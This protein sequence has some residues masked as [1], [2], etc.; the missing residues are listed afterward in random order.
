MRLTGFA[1]IGTLF[2][3]TGCSQVT[4]AP[5]VRETV[6]YDILWEKSGTYSRLGRAIRI[7][8]R[9]EATLAQIPVPEVPVDFSSQMVLVAGLGPITSD[10]MG[11]RI[12]R[13]WQDGSRIRVQEKRI[14]PGP[15]QKTGLHPA[16]PWTVVVVP[17]SD[18]NVE[19]Y[20]PR[21]PDDLLRERSA[22]GG[23]PEP[24]GGILSPLGR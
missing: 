2:L 7:V 3:L 15:D 11:I 10:D 22:V 1:L 6:D 23:T 5:P 13:V 18:L 8:A 4:E 14:H 12:E 19:G 20:S 9:D 24:R 17:R 16:S 21:V